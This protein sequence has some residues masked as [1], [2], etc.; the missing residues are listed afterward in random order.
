MRFNSKRT[1]FLIK[2]LK[3]KEDK[4]RKRHAGQFKKNPFPYSR[5]EA[6]R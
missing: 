5:P 2:V 1:H 3:Q 4:A 6:K